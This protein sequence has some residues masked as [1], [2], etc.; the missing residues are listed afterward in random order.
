[1]QLNNST[2]MRVKQRWSSTNQANNPLLVRSTLDAVPLVT[3]RCR[4]SSHIHSQQKHLRPPLPSACTSYHII[5]RYHHCQR[6][7][8]IPFKNR[9]LPTAE[10][11][12]HHW[13]ND[14]WYT[15]TGRHAWTCVTLITMIV[16]ILGWIFQTSV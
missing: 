4:H 12:T 11:R 10:V 14:S 15:S 2:G 9:I 3:V 13:T 16:L 6:A 7:N 1:M 5:N 8:N